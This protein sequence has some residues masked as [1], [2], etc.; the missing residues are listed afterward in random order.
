[1]AIAI[2]FDVIAG[3]NGARQCAAP[4]RIVLALVW[5]LIAF[6]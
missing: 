6:Q 2:L 3:L 4:E 5:E 1:L